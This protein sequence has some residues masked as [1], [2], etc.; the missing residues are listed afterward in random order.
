MIRW[1]FVNEIKRSLNFFELNGYDATLGMNANS[2]V[3]TEQCVTKIFKLLELIKAFLKSAVVCLS[4]G[5]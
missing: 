1:N 2:A 5:F 3:I 4:M